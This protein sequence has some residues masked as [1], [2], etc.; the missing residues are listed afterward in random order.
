[1][2][3]DGILLME[4]RR[5]ILPKLVNVPIPERVALL[6]CGGSSAVYHSMVSSETKRFTGFHSNS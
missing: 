1:M 2:P 6:E 4:G 3:R 5:L